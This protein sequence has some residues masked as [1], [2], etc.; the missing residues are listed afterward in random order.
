MGEYPR[1]D[2][3][4]DQTP[5]LVGSMLGNFDHAKKYRTKNG[6]DSGEAKKAKRLA[7]N[8]KD[9]VDDGFRKIAGGLDGIADAYASKAA[10]TD[11]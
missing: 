9:G 3:D 11:G 2:S 6:D 8:S 1:K 10:S 5:L 7:H 4:D